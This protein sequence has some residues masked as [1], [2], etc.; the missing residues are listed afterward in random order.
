M[1]VNSPLREVNF[2]GSGGSA[3]AATTSAAGAEPGEVSEDHL[4]RVLSN[5]RRRSIVAFLD[6]EDGPVHRRALVEHLASGDGERERVAM[7]LHHVHLPM[8]ADAG[9]LVHDQDADTLRSGE[10]VRRALGV[11]TTPP[12]DRGANG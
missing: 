11:L 3:G 7:R 8:L 6:A 2:D 1:R 10:N 5:G 9:L 12:G 4:R